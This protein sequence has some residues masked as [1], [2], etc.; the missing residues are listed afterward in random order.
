[1][2]FIRSHI[3]NDSLTCH[4]HSSSVSI[5]HSWFLHIIDSKLRWDNSDYIAAEEHSLLVSALEG[6]SW[7]LQSDGAHSSN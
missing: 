3:E 5:M 2:T 7:Y 6:R 4:I 1:M